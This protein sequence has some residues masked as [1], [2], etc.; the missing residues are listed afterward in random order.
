M[1]INK[2]LNNNVI[3]SIK[4][5]Q[6]VIVMGR[7]IA[8]N[9]RVGEDIDE[10]KVEKIFTLEDQDITKKF[11]T[12]IADIPMEYMELSE[13][14]ILFAKQKLGK[15][16]ND[17]IYISLTDHIHFAIERYNQNLPIK[18]GLLWETKNLYKEE[19]EI[20]LEA[21][22]K[23]CDRFNV[24]LP[25]DE[26]GFIALHIV[27]AQFNEDM[28]NTVDMT[29]VIQ[30]VLTIVK[31][32]FKIEF[33]ES[34]LNYHRFITHLKFFAHRLVKGEH[35]KNSQEDDLLNVII[36]KYPDAYQCSLK[37]KKFVEKQY[38][39]ELTEEELLYLTI[40]IERVVKK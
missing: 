9:K 37:I 22:N 18:N 25:E 39:Y 1:K 11:K 12:L 6:E 33:D 30:D 35:H 20:G 32:S 23:I 21:L 27:N 24:I 13:E 31:Y 28:T 34:S 29:K 19:F 16:L 26:A 40:H 5:D 2:V 3:V 7:G 14:I 38:R 4:D 8:F 17:S 36:N 10:D 15:E